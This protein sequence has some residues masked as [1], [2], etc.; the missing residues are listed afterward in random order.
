M[1]DPHGRAKGASANGDGSFRVP[2]VGELIDDKYRVE[3]TLGTGGQ[4]V[5]LRARDERLARDVAVKIVRPELV[6]DRHT[7]DQFLREARSMARVRHPNVVEIYAFGEVE[8]APY[9]V[10]EFVPGIDLFH[11]FRQRK[12]APLN[13]DE[14]IGLLEQVCR[15]A[16]AMHAKGAVHHDLKPSNILIGPAFRCVITDLGLTRI[17]AGTKTSGKRFLGGTPGYLAPEVAACKDTPSE[18]APRSDV[19]GIGAIAYELLVGRPPFEHEDP[20]ELIRLHLTQSPEPPSV[21]RPELPAAIDPVILSALA[22]EPRDRTATAGQFRQGLLDARQS[23]QASLNAWSV[24]IADDDEDFQAWMRAVVS[25]ALPGAKVRCA[26]D[27]TSALTQIMRE[28]PDLVIADLDM[29]GLN[30][31][32]LTAA[33]QGIPEARGLPIV[34]TTAVGGAPDW[35]LLQ[36]MGAR[37]FL[38]KPVDPSALTSLVRRLL[39]PTG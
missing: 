4:G 17:V 14:A 31:V 9:F 37:G 15:G 29:P 2:E 10:M 5:V 22:K 28:T 19:Y 32:E 33:I 24:L 3:S 35:Q 23:V 38:L 11:W 30:G 39:H 25:D 7:R 12:R 26:P 20:D 13:L 21:R 16:D 36:S 27:G 1:S 34:V 18:F 8:S 6:R